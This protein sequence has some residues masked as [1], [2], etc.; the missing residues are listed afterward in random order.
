MERFDIRGE[1]WGLQKRTDGLGSMC[2]AHDALWYRRQYH[3][4]LINYVAAVLVCG[5]LAAYL[6]YHKHDPTP[7]AAPTLDLEEVGR[8]T[9]EQQ[10]L[11]AQLSDAKKK[12]ADLKVKATQLEKMVKTQNVVLQ[13]R[14]Q[15]LRDLA[16]SVPAQPV[17]LEA[18]KKEAATEKGLRQVVARNFGADIAKR[19]RVA[20]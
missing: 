9:Q 16:V 11:Q 4:A 8:V 7:V 2:W 1:N 6:V 13:Q 3:M 12:I 17:I 14:E 20:E 19:M 18:I 15:Q 10:Q 5:V